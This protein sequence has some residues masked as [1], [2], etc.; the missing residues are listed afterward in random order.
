MQYQLWQYYVW[1]WHVDRSLILQQLLAS[2]GF[3]FVNRGSLFHIVAACVHTANIGDGNT[4]LNT[5]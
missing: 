5:R 3:A 2:H 1:N 4:D